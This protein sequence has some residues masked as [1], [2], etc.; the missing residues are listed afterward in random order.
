[1][2][3]IYICSPPIYR[4]LFEL[5]V[6]TGPPYMTWW[7][8]WCTWFIRHLGVLKTIL[9]LLVHYM[10]LFHRWPFD[11]ISP[12]VSIL[13]HSFKTLSQNTGLL[14]NCKHWECYMS[15]MI[16]FS[17]KNMALSQLEPMKWERNLMHSMDKVTQCY[18]WIYS[19]SELML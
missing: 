15:Y 18:S 19:R 6:C 17:E 4:A 11:Q 8:I 16:S 1:M 14:C 10:P 12:N 9:S 5:S 13:A 7:V 2:T 3:H